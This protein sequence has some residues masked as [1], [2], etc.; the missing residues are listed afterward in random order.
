MEGCKD[1]TLPWWLRLTLR[2]GKNTTLSFF[3]LF[4]LVGIYIWQPNSY[5]WKVFS[6]PPVE[7]KV[8]C[9]INYQIIQADIICKESVLSLPGSRL[10]C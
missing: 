6:Q 10:C 3:S 8:L 1:H 7:F 4:K 5:H 9:M 2:M